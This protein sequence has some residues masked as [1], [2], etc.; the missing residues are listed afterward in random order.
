MGF[1]DFFKP[2]GRNVAP[3]F[4]RINFPQIEKNLSGRNLNLAG[5]EHFNFSLAHIAPN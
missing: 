3:H 5:A 4:N 2:P 1:L